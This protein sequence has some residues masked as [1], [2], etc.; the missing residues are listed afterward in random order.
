MIEMKVSGTDNT[1]VEAGARTYDV[2]IE[3]HPMT[4]TE[5]KVTEDQQSSPRRDQ[6][7]DLAFHQSKEKHKLV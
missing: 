7:N 4:A 2:P 5:L 3:T 6:R 1:T